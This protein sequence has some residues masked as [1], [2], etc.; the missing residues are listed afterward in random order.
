MCRSAP[1]DCSSRIDGM[2]QVVLSLVNMF[3]CRGCE[4]PNIRYAFQRGLRIR[5]CQHG[6]QAI[7]PFCLMLVR[8]VGGGS[9]A[10]VSAHPLCGVSLLTST[11]H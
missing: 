6:Q 1:V 10:P 4:I 7:L 3:W 11:A 5:N 2:I 9:N 8:L